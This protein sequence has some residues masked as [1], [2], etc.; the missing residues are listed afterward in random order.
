M[1]NITNAERERRRQAEENMRNLGIGLAV[2]AILLP[3]I[4]KII[5]WCFIFL[6]KLC[7][8]ILKV[9][10]IALTWMYKYPLYAGL[11][12]SVFFV[13]STSYQ[14]YGYMILGF[15]IVYTIICIIFASNSLELPDDFPLETKSLQQLFQCFGK[16]A[17]NDGHG[18]I[19]KW[20][21]CF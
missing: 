16:F 7:F 21:E 3:I 13:C 9:A 15:C 2:L 1:G 17:A 18:R 11:I 4:F 10:W 14:V 12:V 6:F 8:W 19:F 20:T 5:K